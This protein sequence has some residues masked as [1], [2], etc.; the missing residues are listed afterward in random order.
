MKRDMDL[1]RSVLLRLEEDIGDRG[2]VYSFQYTNKKMVVE[3]YA[4]EE[5]SG[6][7]AML[8]NSP[9]VEGKRAL[10]GEFLV[11]GLTWE[12]REFLDSIRGNDVWQKTKAGVE[13]IGGVGLGF[14]WEI[15]KGVIKNELKA[16]LGID[17]S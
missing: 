9:F 3:G 12:G 10:S 1:I 16:K 4:D 7:L 6:H 14:V 5:V 8:L 13:K 15:A 17:P 2:A 11:K